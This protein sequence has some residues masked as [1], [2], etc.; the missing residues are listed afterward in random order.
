VNAATDMERQQ[1]PPAK[2]CAATKYQAHELCPS[3][4]AV[5]YVP[6]AASHETIEGT[7]SFRSARRLP[8]LTYFCKYTGGCISRCSQPMA[9]LSGKSSKNDQDFLECIRKTCSDS[10][11]L[12]ILDAR[13]RVAASGNRFKG[14]GTEDSSTYKNTRLFFMDIE[15]IHAM[16]E[17][18]DQLWK[19]CTTNNAADSDW[20][21]SL[22]ATKWLSHIQGVLSA[23]LTTMQYVIRGEPVIVHCSDGWDRTPQMC[24]LAQLMIDPYYRTFKGYQVLIEK[25]FLAFGHKFGHRIGHPDHPDERSPVFLQ[26]LDCTWQMMQQFPHEFEFT[27]HYLVTIF[28]YMHSGW[29]GN[30]LDN[31]DK[32]RTLR[33]QF[34]P[35]LSLWSLLDAFS[36]DPE[37]RNPT[38]KP[39]TVF[40]HCV[41][42]PCCSLKM[43]RLWNESYLRFDKIYF[44]SDQSNTGE[45]TAES[46]NLLQADILDATLPMPISRNNSGV[47]A[48]LEREDSKLSE[49][50]HSDSDVGTAAPD[51]LQFWMPKRD[52]TSC[53]SCQRSFSLWRKKRHC[54]QW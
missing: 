4:P 24:A 1:I 17:S 30:F 42:T 53:K 15:N 38:Y 33:Q 9:G 11:T 50:G 20:F 34:Q 18:V 48:E 5:V 10:A 32:L 22:N 44:E 3:Y 51:G 39:T 36:K 43:L 16:R 25:D 31:S 23:S 28:E 41:L 47:G 45:S 14:K 46:A 37:A 26:F 6:S 21:I 13:S 54:Y 2:W 12:F 35:S 27:S 29:F 40:P 49:N 8:A 7:A 52:A 19:L